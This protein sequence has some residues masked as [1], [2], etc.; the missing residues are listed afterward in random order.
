M[1]KQ[2][3]ALAIDGP[4]G[5]GKSTVA[6]TA[7]KLLDFVYIDTG[8]MYRA[9]AWK[10]VELKINLED[11]N[12]LG[13]L[14]KQTTWVF[15]QNGERLLLDDRDVSEII[16]SPQITNLTKFAAR[17]SSVRTHLV[18]LQQQMASEKPSAME[19]RDITTVVLPNAKWRFFLTAT[20]EVR[21]KRRVHDNQQRGFPADYQ[22][23]LSEIIARD[24]SDNSI[25]P[26][27]NAQ[28]IANNG[29]GIILLDTSNLTIDEVI[30][31]IVEKIKSDEK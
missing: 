27:K 16:R 6:R 13:V 22:E 10:A 26:M 19:G 17:A 14:A 4:A 23:I 12:A 1:Q 15:Q 2:I 11:E 28:V 21:A 31:T 25:G 5:S 29:G 18:A 7:A 24:A 8:A 20:P 9:L 3:I 30:K